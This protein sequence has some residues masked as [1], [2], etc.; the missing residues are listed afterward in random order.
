MMNIKKSINKNINLYRKIFCFFVKKGKKIKFLKILNTVFTKLCFITKKPIHYLLT[1][2][3]I[4]L[5]VFV[6]TKTIKTR[7]NVHIVPFPSNF[8]RR[9]YLILK[10]I[11]FILLK[12]SNK[13]SFS[14]KLLTE[15][16]F[17]LEKKNL[18]F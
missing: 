5:N 18:K 9:T 10:W 16:L 2:L 3:F 11:S 15:I 12:N 4:I 6:E 8:K 7:R 14:S 13:V 17:I 1:K